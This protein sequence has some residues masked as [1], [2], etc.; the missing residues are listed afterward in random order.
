MVT[1]GWGRRNGELVS[2]GMEF[3]GNN[4]R[5]GGLHITDAL[6]V[7]QLHTY[8]WLKNDKCYAMSILP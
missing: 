2:N 8:K 3:T 7:T 6:N 5:F 1:W 4:E